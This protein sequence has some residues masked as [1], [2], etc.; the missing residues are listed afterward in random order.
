MDGMQLIR[1][2]RG[3]MAKVARDLG[4]SR[5]AVADWQRVPAELLPAVEAS[6]GI[7]RHQLRPD[8]CFPPCP[9]GRRAVEVA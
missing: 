4:L 9:K 7:P 2:Q 1:S 6:T 8:I 3:L 5:S